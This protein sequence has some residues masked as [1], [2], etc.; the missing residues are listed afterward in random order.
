MMHV[1][2]IRRTGDQHT[3]IAKLRR[4]H[5]DVDR[6]VAAWAALLSGVDC[7]ISDRGPCCPTTRVVTTAW[8]E[9]DNE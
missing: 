5:D 7:E 1:V 9:N 6:V 2:L 4:E 3:F 8:M